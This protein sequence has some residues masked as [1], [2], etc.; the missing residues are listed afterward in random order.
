MKKSY[1]YSRENIQSSSDTSGLALTFILLIVFAIVSGIAYAFIGFTHTFVV[2]LIVF[3]II[4]LMS[5]IWGIFSFIR[6]L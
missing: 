3:G 6:S 1:I 4:A 5:F 2:M